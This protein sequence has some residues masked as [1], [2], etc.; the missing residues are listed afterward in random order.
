[1]EWGQRQC[2][3]GRG[4]TAPGSGV[5]V[6]VGNMI[7]DG[8]GGPGA[9]GQKIGREAEGWCGRW[10]DSLLGR[11]VLCGEEKG[12]SPMLGGPPNHS[13]KATKSAGVCAGLRVCVSSLS[14]KLS[15]AFGRLS[16]A[17]MH[18]G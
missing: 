18:S 6:V 3:A 11:G 12:V 15:L 4:R 17:V 16:S 14:L 8:R 5:A 9:P 10:E 7:T 2:L 1:M 13:L